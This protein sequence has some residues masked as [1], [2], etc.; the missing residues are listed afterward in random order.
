MMYKVDLVASLP[1]YFSH[2]QPIW[3]KLPGEVKGDVRI[4]DAAAQAPP[5]NRVC[6]VASWQDMQPL[7]GLTKFIYV[8]HGSGQQ[9]GGDP[10]SAHWAGYS[11]SGGERHQG[12]IGYICPSDAVAARWTRAP[13]VA[14][15]CPALDPWHVNA[16]RALDAEPGTVGFVFHWPCL[17]APEAN[18]AFWHYAPVLRE[19]V[20]NLN[21]QGWRC[22]GTGHP[23]WEGSLDGPL[24]NAGF[25]VNPT[26]SLLCEV[27]IVDN[28]SVAFE[29]ASL[30][31]HIVNLN[32]PAYRRDVHHGLRFW[33][34]VP[35]IQ[36]DEPEQLLAL[37]LRRDVLDNPESARL[38]DSAAEHAYKYR[39]GSSAQRAADAIMAWIA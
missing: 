11:A 23:K 33:D 30:G 35:G 12:C 27:L 8:E 22:F 21:A 25:A 24:R 16:D 9:Y 29:G 32:A 19:V 2:L 20:E 13:A 37:D 28:S 1:H 6:L 10:K 26:S 15:G 4:N 7:R 14:V 39:D 38:R 18:T 36:I 3:D 5:R 34:H 31:R 17:V